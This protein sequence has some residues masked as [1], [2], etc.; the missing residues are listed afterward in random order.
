MR[1]NMRKIREIEQ[2]TRTELIRY[3][4]DVLFLRVY[5]KHLMTVYDHRNQV[6]FLEQ[7]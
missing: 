3:D 7:N 6:E 2:G 4:F 5:T 1:Y